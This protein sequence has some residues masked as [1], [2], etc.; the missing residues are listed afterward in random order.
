MQWGPAA[1]RPGFCRVRQ[2]VCHGDFMLPNVV[3]NPETF[4][5]AGVIDVGSLAVGDRGRD[6]T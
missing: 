3:L 5:V 4:E 6:M 1:E 2:V